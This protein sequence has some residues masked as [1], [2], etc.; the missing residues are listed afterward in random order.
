MLLT[1]IMQFQHRVGINLGYAC[2]CGFILLCSCNEIYTE[3]YAM[4]MYHVMSTI[5]FGK[6]HEIKAI[7]EFDLKWWKMLEE[8][9]H[10][11]RILTAEEL[12]LSETTEVWLTGADLLKRGVVMPMDLYARRRALQP[13]T[14]DFYI[15]GNEVYRREGNMFQRYVKDIRSKNRQVDYHTIL[16]KNFNNN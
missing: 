5:S 7:N 14:T 16:V 6:V 11:D 8:I 9:S 12:K 13:N 4:F 1:Q 2:S 10:A 15:V 3:P